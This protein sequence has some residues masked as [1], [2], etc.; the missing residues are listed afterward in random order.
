MLL[1]ATTPAVADTGSMSVE[2]IDAITRRPIDR[3]MVSAESRDGTLYSGA[4]ENGAVIIEDLPDGF[5]TFRAESAGY[6]TAVEPAVRVLERRTGRVR[7]ELQPVLETPLSDTLEEVVVIG[8][9][10]EADP[11][12]TVS[13]SFMNREELRN[14]PGSGSDV[15]RALSGLPGLVS[16]GEFASFS[17]RGHGPR[18]NLIYVD[19]FPFQ[20][21]VHFEQTLGEE[22][23]IVNGGRYS[24]FA[25]NAV[26]GAE[27]SPGGWS[28]EFGGRK[29]SLLQF[30]VVDG[31]PSAVG[32]VRLDLAGLEFLYQGPSGFHDDTTMFVQARRFDFGQLFDLIGEDDI[33]SPVMTDVIV[34]TRTQFDD[35]DEF[36]FL[37]IYAPEESTRDVENVIAAVDEPEGI[38]DV[39]LLDEDQDLALVGG[40]WRRLFGS[41]GQ[42]TNRVYV[43]GFDK[44]SSEGEAYPDLV[45]PGTPPEGVPVR[46]KLLTVREEETEFG[47]RSDVS[48]GN[49]FGL[50]TAGLHL[51]SEDIN[52]STELREDWIQYLYNSDDPRPPG[53]NYIVLQPDDIN[54]VY[55]ASETNYGVYGEQVFEWGDASLR[56]GLRYDYD[57]FTGESLVSPRL[58]FNTMIS[59]YLSLSASAGIFYESPSTLVRAADPDNFDLE[60]EE[61]GHVSAGISYRFSDNWRVLVEAYYQQIDNRLVADSRTDLRVTNDGEGT[62][63]GAD[64]VLTR[65]FADGWTADLVYAWNRF[66]VDDNDG[67]GEYDWDFNREHFVSLGGRWEIN[68]R[69][70][71]G[72]RWKYGSGQP[73]DRYI[74]H[75]DVL[76]PFP[77]VR[78]SQEFTAKNVDRDDAFHSLDVRV[79]Y[80]RPV[81]P[82]DLVLFLDVLNVY[83]GPTGEPPELNILTGELISDEE[84]ALPLMGLIVEYAW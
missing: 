25:P 83:G 50:F 12:G 19:G 51:A 63:L 54:S 26:S 46:D 34:K 77:P 23:E 27:F 48:V 47:W 57:G 59:P 40:T 18:N 1:F 14:A 13:S 42:W 64:F 82:I 53:A 70:Q 32:S 2:A 58:N 45:P 22:A 28:A 41:D 37:L 7:F 72:A 35:D 81:G 3:V 71:L 66:R 78:Y 33:G 69:W 17:V 56:A 39:S 52:Y 5:F 30:D 43:R 74:V 79:D 15:M 84:E 76:A 68:E 21:V 36:E 67:R 20:Q 29:A 73:I 9:A 75:D 62:N 31:A 24:I 38:E 55:D 6:V 11:F 49:R 61:L 4:T 10:R 80:R 60:N 16:T 44:V 65:E 8:R